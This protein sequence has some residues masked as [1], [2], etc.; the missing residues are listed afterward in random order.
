M[1]SPWWL[2]PLL[3]PGGTQSLGLFFCV[4][5]LLSGIVSRDRPRRLRPFRRWKPD[6]CFWVL[7]VWSAAAPAP[8]YASLYSALFSSGAG[9]RMARGPA[10]SAGAAPGELTDRPGF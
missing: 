6:P 3:A 9:E 1:R 8:P 4:I 2:V 7:G 10:F 5:F